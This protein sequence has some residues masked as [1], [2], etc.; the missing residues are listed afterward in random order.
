MAQESIVQMILTAQADTEEPNRLT[1]KLTTADHEIIMDIAAYMAGQDEF[2]A[3]NGL[4]CPCPAGMSMTQRLNFFTA[5]QW[6]R[7]DLMQWVNAD[8]NGI[9]PHR[10]PGE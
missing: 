6:E 7:H 3:C 10:L 1:S 5:Q 8:R 2:M 4:P 9:L